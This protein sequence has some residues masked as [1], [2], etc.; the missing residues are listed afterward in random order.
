MGPG[1]DAAS[2]TR[3]REVTFESGSL[4]GKDGAD[5]VS[6]TALITTTNPLRGAYSMR[7]SAAQSFVEASFPPANELY[8]S[9][10]FAPATLPAAPASTL[11]EAPA[12]DMDAIVDAASAKT[13]HVVGPR[14]QRPSGTAIPRH[15]GAHITTEPRY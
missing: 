10:V 5:T 3:I 15:S 8:A 12:L 4:I 11:A 13:P 1:V 6:G 14:I 9:L 7:V 2:S